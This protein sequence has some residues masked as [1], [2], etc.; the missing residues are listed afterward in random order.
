MVDVDIDLPA[1]LCTHRCRTNILIAA[2]ATLTVYALLFEPR[3]HHG[4]STG[5]GTIRIVEFE[6]IEVEFDMADLEEELDS[7]NPVHVVEYHSPLDENIFQPR[8]DSMADRI[9]RNDERPDVRGPQGMNML[10]FGL[11]PSLPSRISSSNAVKFHRVWTMADRLINRKGLWSAGD[12]RQVD[13]I[14]EAMSLAPISGVDQL[15][16]GEYVSGTADKW[17]VTL[18]GGQKVV[19]KLVWS[20]LCSQFVI[21]EARCGIEQFGYRTAAASFILAHT[22]PC[23][24]IIFHGTIRTS[25]CNAVLFT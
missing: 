23:L 14:L 17:L 25:E 3:H 12:E 6:G 11:A 20:V 2:I 15:D 8:T 9:W 22:G 18:V 7:Y 13:A 10:D 24:K 1:S 19:L 21:D 16:I 5:N 4:R